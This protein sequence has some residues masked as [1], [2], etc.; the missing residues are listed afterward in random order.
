M[1]S[2]EG[3]LKKAEGGYKQPPLTT[4]VATPGISGVWTARSSHFGTVFR[5]QFE[6]VDSK[7]GVYLCRVTFSESR[8][9]WHLRQA[10]PLSPVAHKFREPPSKLFPHLT[11]ADQLLI[12][13]SG[14]RVFEAVMNSFAVT[15]EDWAG[16]LGV[17]ARQL[18]TPIG[19]VGGWGFMTCSAGRPA[20]V[21]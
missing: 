10:Y 9:G 21:S 4:T 17:I 19:R 14:R 8:C 20:S 13:R 7:S 2:F 5:G 15:G 11:K 18:K 16:L 6:F 1:L 3:T 12:R